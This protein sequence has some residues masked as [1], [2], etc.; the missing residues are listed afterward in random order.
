MFAPGGQ[1]GQPTWEVLAGMAVL[2]GLGL[3]LRRRG[4]AHRWG[5]GA[6]GEEHTAAVL[7]ALGR[8]VGIRHDLALTGTGANIDHVVV[9][10]W[11]VTVV[12]TK[13]W[14]GDVRLSRRGIICDGKVRRGVIEQVEMQRDVV[15]RVLVEAGVDAPVDAV[16]VIH[17]ARIR[18]GLG[19]RRV[20]GGVPVHTGAS[21]G[22]AL[23]RRWRRPRLS[24]A[25]RR[26]VLGALD[27][28][29]GAR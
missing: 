12:E 13:H 16:V 9:T 26:V 22:R 27:D 8:R 18:R 28:G 17:G 11:A 19:R 14:G 6:L 1:P 10:R 23:R 20:V 5:H 29:L 25:T 24:G 4:V 15:E 7:D 3:W 21:L 2:G